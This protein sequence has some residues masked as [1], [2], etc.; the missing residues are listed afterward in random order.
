METIFCYVMSLYYT[1]ENLNTECTPKFLLYQGLHAGFPKQRF[2]K[3]NQK[4][5]MHLIP[6]LFRKYNYPGEN[7]II[8]RNYLVA[9]AELF[10]VT[11]AYFFSDIGAEFFYLA[12]QAELFSRIGEI[13]QLQRQ[14]YSQFRQNYSADR[15][16]YSA[17]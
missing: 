8:R 10:R 14:N 16:I 3:C 1:F 17:V 11:Q 15:R 13:I 9:Q 2:L 6:A 7:G 5:I 4:S 12:A